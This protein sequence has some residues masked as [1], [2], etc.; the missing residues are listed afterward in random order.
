MQKIKEIIAKEKT[1]SILNHN[2][3]LLEKKSKNLQAQ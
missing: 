2:T 3:K 1:I